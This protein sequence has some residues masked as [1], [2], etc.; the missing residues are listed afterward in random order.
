MSMS[1]NTKIILLNILGIF[2][3]VFFWPLWY[4]KWAPDINLPAS[5]SSNLFIFVG[6]LYGSIGA[7]LAIL[8]FLTAYLQSRKA[9]NRLLKIASLTLLILM[10]AVF[11]FLTVVWTLTPT[12]NNIDPGM[13]PTNSNGLL[14]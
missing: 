6:H 8:L 10:S 3:G 1:K 7:I 9:K 14:K 5:W 11:L 13:T 2:F 4:N 12:P